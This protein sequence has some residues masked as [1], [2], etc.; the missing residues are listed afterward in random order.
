M[1]A[2][3]LTD[4]GRLKS[5]E[6]PSVISVLVLEDLA[7]ALYLPL[8]AVLLAEQSLEVATLSIVVALASVSLILLV[9]L[10]YGRLLVRIVAHQSDEVILFTAFGL[11][12]LVAGVAQQLRVSGAVGAFL[13][14]IALSGPIAERAHRLL[15]SL[16]DLFAAIFFLFFGLQVDPST[17]PPILLVA[18]ALA[19][20]TSLTK[21]IVGWWA[22]RRDGVDGL[23]GLRAGTALV[24]R[25]EFSIVIAGMGV[26]AGVEPQLGVLATAYVLLLATVGPILPRTIEPLS[27]ILTGRKA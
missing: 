27:A 22:A 10:R 17:L 21:V 9:A 18:A 7:M 11:V 13:V 16:R 24:A 23:G 5:P 19:L 4:L 12:L 15:A 1:I 8:V 3:V 26:A 25:G 2:K 14:G 20:M 6:T